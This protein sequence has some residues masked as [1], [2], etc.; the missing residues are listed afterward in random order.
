MFFLLFL[1]KKKTKNFAAQPTNIQEVGLKVV[2]DNMFC[3]VFH[4]VPFL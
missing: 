3:S 4:S 1:K 2:L